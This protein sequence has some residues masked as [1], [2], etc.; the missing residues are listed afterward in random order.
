MPLE[1]LQ[2]YESSDL[3]SIR[4][5]FNKN[6]GL[7]LLPPSTVLRIR[8]LKLHRKRK[9]GSRGEVVKDAVHS[10]NVSVNLKNCPCIKINPIHPSRNL[11]N[12]HL[13]TANASSIKNKL[14]LVSDF[15]EK[16]KIDAFVITET[17]LKDCQS[18]NAWIKSCALNS[19]KY[20]FSTVNRQNKKGGGVALVC[21]S[22]LKPKLV[23]QGCS[24]S[25]EFGIWTMK[26]SGKLLTITG[27]YHPPHSETNTHSGFTNSLTLAMSDQ[28]TK[29][30]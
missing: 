14:E 25:M 4:S 11:L 10:N 28:N 18:D 5:M 22:N 6:P 2:V 19:D 13:G 29:T 27:I 20:T 1:N 15:L 9:R 21:K 17:W 7:R 24:N 3:R 23:L 12:I 30:Y 8:S 26:T 16:S